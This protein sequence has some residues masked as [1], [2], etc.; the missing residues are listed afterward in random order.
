MNPSTATQTST[1]VLK[2]ITINGTVHFATI[3][4]QARQRREQWK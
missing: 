1:G 4:S 3:G 2:Q